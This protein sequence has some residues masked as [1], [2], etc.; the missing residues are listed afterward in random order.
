LIAYHPLGIVNQSTESNI[1]QQISS[2]Q[3]KMAM[4]PHYLWAAGHFLLLSSTGTSSSLLHLASL[5]RFTFL[6]IR[7]TV[8][9]TITPLFHITSSYRLGIHY[10]VIQQGA[11]DELLV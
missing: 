5:T 11:I 1:N 6:P 2:S 3:A 9:N 10:R 8:T 7:C 4:D